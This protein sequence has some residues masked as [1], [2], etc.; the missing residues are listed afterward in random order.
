MTTTIHK[1]FIAGKWVASKSRKTFANI[2][3]ARKGEVVG[4]FQ[5]STPD[6]VER[7]VLLV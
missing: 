1:N 6:D 7:A 4:R 3:P 5:Q 2:N